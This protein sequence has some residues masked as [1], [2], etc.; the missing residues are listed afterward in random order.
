MV[1]DSGLPEKEKAYLEAQFFL[2]LARSY[3]AS[4]SVLA[5]DF[6]QKSLASASITQ[7]KS[8]RSA[9]WRSYGTFLF[10]RSNFL[11]ADSAYLISEMLA[12]ASKDIRSQVESYQMLATN[13][14]YRF[15]EEQDEGL[16]QQSMSYLSKC[17]ALSNVYLVTTYELKAYNFHD[18]LYL[19]EGD[20]P[21]AYHPVGDSAIFYYKKTLDEAQKAG[22]LDIMSWMIENITDLCEL[23][24]MLTGEDCNKLLN[25]K[26]YKVFLSEN[27]KSLIENMRSDLENSN[28][29]I[30]SAEK[31]LERSINKRR[32]A[33]SWGISAAGLL[34][35]G[36][37]F[38]LLLQRARNRRL[39]ARMEA[40]R[41][42]INP[43]FFS[44]SLNAIE[45]L[46][47]S[48]KNELA[49][50]YL[51][52]FSRL[53]RG[54][55]RSS[56]SPMTSLAEELQTLKHFLALEKLRFRDKLDYDIQVDPEIN[57]RE[58]EVPALILQ[59]YAENAI[60]HG[61]KPLSGHGYLKVKVQK[62]KNSLLCI[63]EDNGIWRIK[64][65][66]SC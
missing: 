20:P 22:D 1:E 42:Q 55:L 28:E 26:N 6:F 23:K 54:I 32:L 33:F 2:D 7:Y 40:L 3:S 25:T 50:K 8:F 24:E 14:G 53:S 52:H 35:A 49:S 41:A 15:V 4:D 19:K 59:P 27:Y 57:A 45:N 30:R 47:I 21:G 46:I 60:I 63:I 5:S 48:N 62:E 43:H 36:L 31:R 38:I 10:N 9:I 61:I 11:Q 37:I 29:R 17:Q 16:Y 51:I 44:N 34:F 18:F 58:F 56:R 39:Q 12:L 66:I 65:S 64:R 13:R